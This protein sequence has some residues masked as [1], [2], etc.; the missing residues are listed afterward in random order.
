MANPRRVLDIIGKYESDKV[1]G[2]EAVNQIG[3]AGGRG[4]LGYSG[5]IRKMKQH[6]GR[7][8][9]DMTVGEIMNLQKDTGISN[10]EWINRGKLHAVGRYQ[11][12]GPTLKERVSKLK[13]DPSQKFTPELQDK[14]ALDYIKEAG[15]ISPWIGPSD[16]ATA[17]ERA[18]IS[19]FLKNPNQPITPSQQSKSLPSNIYKE[20]KPDATQ[21]TVPTQKNQ[22]QLPGQPININLIVPGAATQKKTKDDFGSQFLKYYIG[23]S[24]ES[25]QMFTG[26]KIDPIGLLT[27]AFSGSTNYFS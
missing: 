27:K 23:K 26:P 12:I 25:P 14:L 2:Y 15:S 16:K 19:A 22:T 18:D 3:V 7:A 4:V 1:G 6:G 9:T 11:F 24:L 17:A 8:L 21:Q 5:D 10:P 13:I 20:F